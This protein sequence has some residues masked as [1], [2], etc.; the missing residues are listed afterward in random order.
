MSAA[1][2]PTPSRWTPRARS[3]GRVRAGDRRGPDAVA[4][5]CRGRRAGCPRGRRSGVDLSAVQ[6]IGVGI[7][8]Q[9]E[10]GDTPSRGARGEPRRRRARPRRPCAGDAGAS[11]LGVPGAGG[12]RRGRPPP[13]ARTPC[14]RA[15]ARPHR[16]RWPTSISGTGVAAAIVLRTACC[17]AVRGTAGEV[18]HVLRSTPNGPLLPVRSARLHRGLRGWWSPI[19][20]RW[21]RSAR[22]C[23]CATSSTPPTR[24]TPS[25][26]ACVPG[27]PAASRPRCARTGAGGRRRCRG[28]RRDA[29]ALPAIGSSTDVA[30]ELSAGAGIPFL[31]SLHLT[32][33]VE[34]LPPGSPAAA[35]RRSSARAAMP[36]TTPRRHWSMAEVVIVRDKAAAGALRRRPHRRSRARTPRP[37][38]GLRPG[39]TPLPVYEALRPR[40]EGVDVSRVRAVRARRVRRHRPR[41]PGG[42]RSVITREV[43]E[44]LG[45]D[46]SRIRMQPDGTPEG[47]EHH[48]EDYEAAI[49]EAGGVDLQLLGVG[50]DGHIGFNEPWLVVRLA[51]AGQDPDP[52]D[53]RGQR[54]LLRPRSTTCPCTA[55]RR[56]SGTIL[57]ARTSRAARVRRGQGRGRRG[58]GRRRRSR[59]P[60]RDPRSSCTRTPTVVVDEAAAS[61]LRPARLLPLHVRQQAR[62][63][64]AVGRSRALS[65][66]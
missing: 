42:Y 45:L 11:R 23:R 51:H 18:G 50:T 34:L 9:I 47:I 19:A 39:S 41:A 46:P 12:E 7:P 55:S 3:P 4:Q 10:P 49:R 62:L 26:R 27:W 57:R 52:A 21:A 48:G 64:G 63:A 28:A 17:G 59:H 43:V 29:A 25:R 13:S 16:A 6:S 5:H 66:R 15:A 14:T 44:P 38:S 61:R 37:S 53:P 32:G 65:P 22:R 58:C 2:R 20:G 40:L 60:F 36:H 30:A 33:R 24:A 31:R 1:P 8:G 54:A 56:D 35:R